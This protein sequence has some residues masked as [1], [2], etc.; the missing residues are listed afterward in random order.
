M[1]NETTTDHYTSGYGTDI[2]LFIIT[3]VSGL[4]IW[5]IFRNPPETDDTH[6]KEAVTNKKEE[7]SVEETAEKILLPSIETLE[8]HWHRFRGPFGTGICTSKHIPA[9]W[10]VKTGSGVQWQSSVPL[11]GASSPVVWGGSIFVTGG[12]ESEYH[13]YCYDADSGERLWT[14]SHNPTVF[15]RGR[16]FEVWG[17]AGYAVPTPVTDGKRVYALFSNLDIVCSDPA[18]NRVWSGNLGFPGLPYGYASSPVRYRDLLIV[19]LDMGR[20]DGNRSRMVALDAATGTTVWEKER[21]VAASWTTPIIIRRTGGDQLVTL[22]EP[23]LRSYDPASGKE[24][25]HADCVRG[26]IAPSPVYA[27]EMVIAAQDGSDLAAVRVTGRGNVTETHTAWRVPGDLPDTVSPVAAG[28]LVFTV[29]S[30]GYLSCFDMSDGSELWITE[31]GER[32]EASPVAAHNSIY[33]LS[34]EGTMILFRPDRKEYRETG[35]M[36]FGEK[37]QATPAF[38]NGRIY[39]RSM[40]MLFSISGDDKKETGSEQNI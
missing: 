6:T 7:N 9:S 39:V 22:A 23:G 14:L 34:S 20:S 27:K 5:M 4:G 13:L 31:L 24:I 25:W 19:M 17:K 40:N 38:A 18:G 30:S 2:I 26:E 8:K 11:P 37:C 15:G 16:T 33:L 1:N 36:Q 28:D 10:S 35:R 12:K 21:P 32:F 3:V 29:H